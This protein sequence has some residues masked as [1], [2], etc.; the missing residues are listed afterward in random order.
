[1][2]VS[3]A[4]LASFL[5][6]SA[7]APVVNVNGHAYMEKPMARN[8]FAN[9]EC[10]WGSTTPG[11][12]PCYSDKQSINQNDGGVCGFD[13]N[14]NPAGD[15]N[16]WL[17]STG[18]PME[19]ESKEIYN[20]GDIITVN[21]VFTAH[22]YGHITVSGCPMEKGKGRDA[23][24][25]CIDAFPLEFVKDNL[26]DM[27]KDSNHKDRG[28]LHG[29]DMRLSMQF[30]LP[31]GLVGEEV[32]LQWV[33]TTANSCVPVGY[34]DYF[35]NHDVPDGD[36]SWKS[37]LA[38][39]LPDMPLTIL[40]NHLDPAQPRGEIFLNC[41]EVTVLGDGSPIST[42]PPVPA[43]I[44]APPVS[45]PVQPPVALPPTNPD[46]T[47]TCGGGN[48]GNGICPDQSHCC[49]GYGYCGTVETGHCDGT[50]VSPVS[51]P[52]DSPVTPPTDNHLSGD[53][54][55]IAYLGNW[56]SCPSDEQIAQYTHIVVAFAVSYSWAAGKNECSETC[57]IATPVVCEN[58]ARPDLLQKWKA[59]GK[60][61]ILSFGGAGMGGSW[62]GDTNDCWDY[63]FGREDQV[64][65]RLTAIVNEMDFD[66]IDIDYE[67]F[68]E[69]NQNGS[70]FTKGAQ[71]QKFLFDV[72]V[73][74][75]NTM[76]AGS[77]LTHAPMEPDMEPDTAYF[78][79]LKSVADSLDFL[80]PQYYNG[81]V[82]SST[83]FPGALSHFTTITNEMFNGDASKIVYGFC[84]DDC[85]T[86][87]LDGYQSAD[88]MEQLSETYPCNGG[89]FL[90][91]AN[92]DTNGE[93]SKPM[94]AQLALDSSNC[95]DREEPN[96]TNP[97]VV[98]PV[99][100]PTAAP[101]TAPVA[102]PTSA[103]VVD[104]LP[105]VP[106]PT[107]APVPDGNSNGCCS[108]DFKTCATWGNESREVC[109]GLGAM[110]WL[111]DGPSDTT[112]VAKDAGCTN[113]IDS[114]CR[115]LV[116][117]GN[118]WWKSCKNDVQ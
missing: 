74:L 49:S 69:D 57:E 39:C 40:P 34:R 43:P 24:Q 12:P 45:S 92:D 84:I 26:F 113:D 101:I 50:P 23:T 5:A 55:L 28:Y 1:M 56:Q 16:K 48:R 60:K 80:M 61:I 54:R 25:E 46:V 65:N 73:G 102:D 104:T 29:H 10:T 33:Y 20:E 67:Y 115:G 99:V 78:N 30:K 53:S 66:G 105:P 7:F 91:V 83:N 44:P 27:P 88:V 77:E 9:I 95:S 36:S 75:R 62:A 14:K 2:T 42:L 117:Q 58:A 59:A 52:V 82:R 8:Y 41:A 38:D 4:V 19:W 111:P 81:Y 72:T 87:N 93:W 94:Q 98:S 96:P 90:W 76:P 13:Q 22:H 47:G 110:M 79:V 32:L 3:N 21:T 118:Q 114:C 15:M 109:E 17:D 97:P 86:F 6:L 63:C 71:A 70:G 100:D 85:G 103:P 106:S 112:C 35:Q 108:Y 64:V 31:P 18:A 11:V 68:Y 51:P 37:N 89:A 116:C 107:V